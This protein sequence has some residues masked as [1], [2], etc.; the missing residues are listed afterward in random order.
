MTY[1]SF[2]RDY[3]EGEGQRKKE[4]EIK[5][6]RAA[7]EEAARKRA[8]VARALTWTASG[9]GLVKGW[10]NRNNIFTISNAQNGTA[11]TNEFSII[12]KGPESFMGTVT[13]TD[14]PSRFEGCYRPPEIGQYTIDVKLCG[15][16]VAKSPFSV[17]V[18]CTICFYHLYFLDAEHISQ[19]L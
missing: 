5:R 7:E 19:G 16:P 10:K 1:V 4:E 11:Q 8:A 18:N 17:Q 12:A 6:Q 15:E 13:D 9:P 2:F 14:L 3:V